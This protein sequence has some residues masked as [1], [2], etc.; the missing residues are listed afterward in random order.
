MEKI[1]WDRIPNF[2]PSE[3]DS[4]DKP[5]SGLDMQ[6][7]F[8]FMLQ[9]AREQAGIPFGINSGF[10]TAEHNEKVGGATSSA[11]LGGWAA[12][13]AATSSRQRFIIINALVKAGF[14][15]IGIGKSFIHVDCNPN[16]PELV[17][18]HYY[19]KD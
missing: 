19:D 14:T 4:P 6:K 10:R 11:H 1:T 17:I 18:W 7:R 13:I 15:R 3:F 8:M 5:G 9:A 12:D 16:L 2:A